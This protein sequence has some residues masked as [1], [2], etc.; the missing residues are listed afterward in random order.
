MKSI[1]VV[2]LLALS[3]SIAQ[4]SSKSN[5]IFIGYLVDHS[6]GKNIAK[7]APQK[8]ERLAENHTRACALDEMCKV[9]GY[10][11][12]S[13][14]H[15]YKL[16]VAGDSIAEAYLNKI[17]EEDHIKVRIDGTFDG[18]MLNVQSITD[19]ARTSKNKGKS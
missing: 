19:A 6:C 11:L 13:N 12:Y 10:G 9:H 1:L 18:K 15:Y 8:A 3:V 16:N 17:T 7:A 4:Q 14:G 5:Q 2:L